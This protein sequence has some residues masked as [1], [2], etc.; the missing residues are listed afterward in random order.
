[1]KVYIN[2]DRNMHVESLGDG[3]FLNAQGAPVLRH[4]CRLESPGKI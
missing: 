1:M 3:V 2:A 4:L